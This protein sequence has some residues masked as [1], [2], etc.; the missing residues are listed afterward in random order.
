[1]N[2]TWTAAD[3]HV[4]HQSR[5]LGSTYPYISHMNYSMLRSILYTKK[6]KS[7]RNDSIYILDLYTIAIDSAIWYISSNL[8]IHRI[9]KC[10]RSFWR[11]C[12]SLF[13]SKV[14][15]Q[16][17]KTQHN[18]P[19]PCF[20]PIQSVRSIRYVPVPTL[21]HRDSSRYLDNWHMIWYD[22]IWSQ[23]STRWGL[24][25]LTFSRRKR[26]VHTVLTESSGDSSTS[27]LCEYFYYVNLH[28]STK[29]CVLYR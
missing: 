5:I 28:Y 25:G 13:I 24:G 17:G 22:M 9:D 11:S 7:S 26:E 20:H 4:N 10:K 19:T 23:I 14:K 3:Q 1:M 12:R 8:L 18:H 27:V 6:K 21:E 15:L 16:C 29:S 2:A